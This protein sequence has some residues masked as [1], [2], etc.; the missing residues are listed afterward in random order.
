MFFKKKLKKKF[1]IKSCKISQ[2]YGSFFLKKIPLKKQNF[3]QNS[4]T[5]KWVYKKFKFQKEKQSKKKNYLQ[6]QLDTSYKIKKNKRSK[7]QQRKKKLFHSKK[8]QNEI[9]FSHK[10]HISSKE[11]KITQQQ[12]KKNFFFIFFSEWTHL[13]IVH[14]LLHRLSDDNGETTAVATANTHTKK[15]SYVNKKKEE[16]KWSRVCYMHKHNNIPRLN[17]S[18]FFF[19][20][21]I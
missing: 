3:P 19:I 10:I 16:F 11:I 20:H 21:R 15:K 9:A 2:F 17:R 6:F 13:F 7:K 12:Q 14:S 1:K 8:D 18:G 4:K 5:I